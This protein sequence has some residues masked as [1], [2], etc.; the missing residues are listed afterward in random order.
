MNIFIST[1]RPG[2][3]ENVY[4]IATISLISGAIAVV[5]L[6]TGFLCCCVVISIYRLVR[7]KKE[8]STNQEINDSVAYYDV[9]SPNECYSRSNVE[10]QLNKNKAYSDVQLR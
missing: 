3:N 6:I 2:E 8:L 9:T 1:A 5:M 10:L 7:R 4:S